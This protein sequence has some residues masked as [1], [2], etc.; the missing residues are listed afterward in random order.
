MTSKLGGR[1]P[2]F[3][4]GNW[5]EDIYLKSPASAI[6]NQGSI[7]LSTPPARTPFG[8]CAP[9]NY[10]LLVSNC[11]S[12]PWSSRGSAFHETIQYF[13]PLEFQRT[14]RSLASLGS[15]RERE[16][17]VF[18]RNDPRPVD[19]SR[20]RARLGMMQGGKPP[21]LDPPQTKHKNQWMVEDDG[22]WNM[23]ETV[24]KVSIMFQS[25]HRPI[26]VLSFD[27]LSF[28][29]LYYGLFTSSL[30]VDVG[31]VERNGVQSQRCTVHSM[32]NFGLH[33][34]DRIS[35]KRQRRRH[36]CKEDQKRHGIRSCLGR[37]P[38]L[39]EAN[40]K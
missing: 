4:R 31:C 21:Q 16:R 23:I 20:C 27:T 9:A 30:R 28:V 13:K 22:D 36:T 11:W 8:F 35:I 3:Y 25:S 14:T 10:K 18:Q 37:P 1:P 6:K 34:H 29:I 24:S 40:V 15:K 39:H 5:Q 7:F 38:P 17:A 26:A 2:P 33:E 19:I 32:E 12:Q